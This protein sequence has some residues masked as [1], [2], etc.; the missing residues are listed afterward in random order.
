MTS[1][2]ALALLLGLR[3]LVKQAAKA[4]IAY[5][6]SQGIPVQVTSTRRTLK[7]Q[8][9]LYRRAQLGL[10]KYPAAKPGT[11]AHEFGMAFDS[12][13]APADQE[14]WNEI[15]RAI[16]FQVPANDI[17]HAQVPNWASVVRRRGR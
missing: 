11:S 5:A 16:G 17:I 14:A 12:V 13:V 15:R 4:A 8:R 3:P 1:G 2:D 6:N 9:W 7:E 10:S